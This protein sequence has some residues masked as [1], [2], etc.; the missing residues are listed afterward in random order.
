MPPPKKMKRSH[1]GAA[2]NAERLQQLGGTEFPEQGESCLQLQRLQTAEAHAIENDQEQMLLR[3]D[4]LNILCLKYN[5]FTV[6][7]YIY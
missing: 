3:A 5:L 7:V 4:V 6:F 2:T 1:S